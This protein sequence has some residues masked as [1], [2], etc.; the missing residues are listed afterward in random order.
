M[1]GWKLNFLRWTAGLTT[2]V[3]ENASTHGDNRSPLEADAESL[4]NT[5]GVASAE[6][7][8]FH[9][10]LGD[11][12]SDALV[13][14]EQGLKYALGLWTCAARSQFTVPEFESSALLF[15]KRLR[16]ISRWKS[17]AAVLDDLIRHALKVR[18][19]KDHRGVD[20]LSDALPFGRLSWRERNAISNAVDC[21]KH[22]SHDA[23]IRVYDAAGN[24]I[25]MYEHAGDF[26]SS[27]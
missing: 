21:A 5:Q 4:A 17:A 23:V 2:D 15:D 19:R 11:L 22:S 26:Q 12:P 8:R 7:H 3:R 10:K 14:V 6:K 27:L 13:E 18:P 9:K 1:C 24:V 25:E 20:L 16:A